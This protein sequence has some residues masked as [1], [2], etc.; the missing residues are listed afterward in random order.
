MIQ[1]YMDK[2]SSV[3]LLNELTAISHGDSKWLL[4]S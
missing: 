3:V 4:L 2:Q 1:D